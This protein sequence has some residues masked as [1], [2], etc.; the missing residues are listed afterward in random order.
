MWIITTRGFLSVVQNAD[1]KTPH[2][3]LLVRGRV[4]ADLDHFADFVARHGDRPVVTATPR[5]D[6]GYRLT[7]SRELFASYLAEH[8]GAL[9]YPNFKN[10]VAEADPE[11][12]HIYTRVWGVLRDLRKIGLK[13][14]SKKTAGR[15]EAIT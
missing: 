2:E 10:E 15:K 6:Y 13:D 3:A 14:E 9:D 11:R 5:F 12:A 1:A 7:A 4:R 8:V